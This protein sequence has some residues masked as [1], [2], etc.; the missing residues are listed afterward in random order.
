M[1]F[2]LML[3]LLNCEEI[4]KDEEGA[5]TRITNLDNCIFTGI[6]QII[7]MLHENKILYCFDFNKNCKNHGN[8]CKNCSTKKRFKKLKSKIKKEYL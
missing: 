1:L 3:K 2:R 4:F 6:G 5:I 7:R 8:F